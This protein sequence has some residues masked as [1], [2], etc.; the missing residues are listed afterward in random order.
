M[1]L[2]HGSQTIIEEPRII[3]SR[4]SKDFYYGFYCTTIER[5]AKRWAS[6]FGDKK[7]YLNVYEYIPKEGLN[8]KVFASMTDEWLDFIASCRAGIPHGYDV[9]EGP[10]AD[11]TIFNYVQNYLE[12]GI[13]REDFWALAKFKY[14]IQQISFNSQKALSALKFIG[15]KE[16]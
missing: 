16:V 7:G 11:D 4:N 14:P 10:M 1:I 8:V 2:F 9:V 13:S 15:A 6:R 12:G 3:V 5:Q